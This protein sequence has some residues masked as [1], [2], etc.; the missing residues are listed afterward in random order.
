MRKYIYVTFLPVIIFCTGLSAFGGTSSSQMIVS[1][2]IVPGCMVTTNP[3]SFGEISNYDPGNAVT[4]TIIA[5]CT[6][7]TSYSISIDAG[8]YLTPLGRRGMAKTDNPA[9]RF[10]YILYWDTFPGGSEPGDPG[11]G[12][13]F[14]SGSLKTGIGDGSDQTYTLI[15]SVIFG[16]SLRSAPIGEYLDTLVV[17]VHF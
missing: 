12:D 9:I 15:G 3:L 10:G 5:K 4:T 11:Y 1:S 16:S 14:P 8:Q 7:Q 17:S 13:T 2:T 6:D